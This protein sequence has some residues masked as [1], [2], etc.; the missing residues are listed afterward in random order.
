MSRIHSFFNS[1]L[2]TKFH[3]WH[4]CQAYTHHL[5]LDYVPNVTRGTCVTYTHSAIIR[6][7]HTQENRNLLF[8]TLSFYRPQCVSESNTQLNP[9]LSSK[10]TTTFPNVH[11]LVSFKL[12]HW[13]R[14]PPSVP[15]GIHQTNFSTDCRP[16][17]DWGEFQMTYVDEEGSPAVQ[18]PIRPGTGRPIVV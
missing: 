13:A 1:G 5:I 9:S 12:H 11:R 14:S 10:I 7:L 18:S 3:T 6:N 16:S 17:P 2:R 15:L 8:T 4:I